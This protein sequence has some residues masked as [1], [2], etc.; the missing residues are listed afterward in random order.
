MSWP[1]LGAGTLSRCKWCRNAAHLSEVHR[2]ECD[3]MAWVGLTWGQGPCE[4]ANGAEMP[5]T[6]RNRIV[7]IMSVA[8]WAYEGL[9]W[10][11]GGG[12][13]QNSSQGQP[14]RVGRVGEAREPASPCSSVLQQGWGSQRTLLLACQ[15]QAAPCQ[16]PDQT[17]PAQHILNG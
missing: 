7:V 6:C 16:P 3:Q 5:P 15:R 11:Q 9:T 4:N 13:R 1:D 14:W 12:G 8:R 2:H 10:G 17:H